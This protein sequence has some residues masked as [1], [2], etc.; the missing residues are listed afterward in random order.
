MKNSEQKIIL[1][2]RS[3][4]NSEVWSDLSKLIKSPHQ[5]LLVHSTDPGY[6]IPKYRA[7][8]LV[9]Y[10]VAKFMLGGL[11]VR[12][13]PLGAKVVSACGLDGYFEFSG[14]FKKN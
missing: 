6:T 5:T 10:G 11:V 14:K 12:A 13:T 4:L 1:E 8:S 7:E 9:A 2:K 3:E